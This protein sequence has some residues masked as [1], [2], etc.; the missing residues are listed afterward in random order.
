MV[1]PSLL[2]IFQLKTYAFCHLTRLWLI[3]LTLSENRIKNSEPCIIRNSNGWPLEDLTLVPSQPGLKKLT[4]TWLWPLG[5]PLGWSNL[6]WI[7][8]YLIM[9]FM[10]P[11]KKVEM[12]AKKPFKKWSYRLIRSMRKRMNLNWMI[13]TV[14][15]L[16]K[17]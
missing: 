3:P 11:L 9:T 15:F 4:L 6:S 16:F 2:K 1:N 12:I 13:S 8:N 14:F 7:L 5:V 17:M 10:L